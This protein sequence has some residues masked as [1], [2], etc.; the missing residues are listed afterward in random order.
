MPEVV[1]SPAQARSW[2]LNL[3]VWLFSAA[4]CPFTAPKCRGGSAL[5]PRYLCCPHRH[6]PEMLGKF[7]QLGGGQCGFTSRQCPN[8]RFPG[9]LEPDLNPGRPLAS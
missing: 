4:C 3:A 9:S 1:R 2:D 8:P 6:L 5:P 7:Q